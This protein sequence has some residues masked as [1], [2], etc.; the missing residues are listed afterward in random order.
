MFTESRGAVTGDNILVGMVNADSLRVLRSCFRRFASGG[1]VLRPIISFD[2][3]V[4]LVPRCL[5]S[6][7]HRHFSVRLSSVLDPIRSE[8]DPP[9]WAQSFTILTLQALT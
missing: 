7:D 4:R 1:V 3:A 8:A 6:E 2:D 9:L 5:P